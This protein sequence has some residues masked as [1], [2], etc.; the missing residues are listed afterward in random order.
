M[1]LPL[2][3]FLSASGGPRYQE[4]GEAL[5]IRGGTRYQEQLGKT[6][7]IRPRPGEAPDIR[8]SLGRP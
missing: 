4:L 2:D 6:L 1:T 3:Q 7:D 5:D 8:P